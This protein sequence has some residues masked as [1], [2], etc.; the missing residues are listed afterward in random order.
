M[1]SC[2]VCFAIHDTPLG[3]TS[4]QFDGFGIQLSDFWDTL[5]KAVSCVA[6]IEKEAQIMAHLWDTLFQK[7]EMLG[8]C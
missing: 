2:I 8:W 7:F 1:Y 3:Y 4:S 5:L 6:K